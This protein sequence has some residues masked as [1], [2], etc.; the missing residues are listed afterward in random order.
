M[1]H[2]E[3]KWALI[4]RK[5]FCVPERWRGGSRTSQAQ[6][7]PFSPRHPSAPGD[8]EQDRFIAPPHASIA[9]WPPLQ[10]PPRNHLGHLSPSSAWTRQ[11]RS[12]APRTGVKH[13]LR[14]SSSGPGTGRELSRKHFAENKTPKAFQQQSTENRLQAQ[15]VGEWEKVTSGGER[16]GGK[17][18]TTEDNPGE[19]G[20]AEV[21]KDFLSAFPAG[22]GGAEG[23]LAAVWP[24]RQAL[25]EALQAHSRHSHSLPA[26][27]S[28]K[29]GSVAR[30]L[31]YLLIAVLLLPWKMFSHRF[32]SSH[33]T[34]L[35]PDHLW[36]QTPWRNRAQRLFFFSL[37][38]FFLA[39][40]I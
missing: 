4:P 1:A 6:P 13:N 20:G 27:A 17:D 34:P 9:M 19:N 12:P 39:I 15:R 5:S 2:S 33:S 28:F 35:H 40:I 38:F 37:Y 10:V 16:E 21:A 18:Q 31:I 24:E 3:R 14:G 25:R 32:N 26:T 22:A 36:S 7:G 30:A 23:Q 29:T 11:Q 8:K